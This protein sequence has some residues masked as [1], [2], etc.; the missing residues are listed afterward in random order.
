MN[1]G[2]WV[3]LWM[4]PLGLILI[5]ALV[6]GIV[7]PA[8]NV[9]SL[10]SPLGFPPTSPGIIQAVTCTPQATTPQANRDNQSNVY[11]SGIS[12]A[13]SRGLSQ[14][15]WAWAQ[16]IQHDIFAY[17][18]NA[19][20]S[21]YNISLG[22][23]GNMT[24]NALNVTSVNC[25][26]PNGRTW[27][28]DGS[29]IYSD[30]LNPARL[31]LLRTGSF[32]LMRQST[33]GYLP[34]VNGSFLAGD[35]DVNE[36]P[37]LA[38][39]VTLFVREHNFWAREL[40]QLQPLWTDDDLFWKAR[41]Y[42]LVEIQRITFEEWLPLVLGG[43]LG[44][45][46]RPPPIPAGIFPAN[47]TTVSAEFAAIG[48]EFYRS[49]LNNNNTYN[50]TNVTQSVL[51]N[52]LEGILGNAW[53]QPALSFDVRVASTQCNSTTQ[54]YDYLAAA[55]T[56]AQELGITT[57][58]TQLYLTFGG[59]AGGVNQ[60]ASIIAQTWSQAPPLYP[61]SSLQLTTIQILVEQLQRVRANDPNWYTLPEMPS[62]VGPTF[63]PL[64]SSATLASVMYRNT[65]LSPIAGASSAF[66]SS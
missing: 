66:I 30:A 56:R 10:P 45:L 62:T 3:L 57:N 43:Y 47:A 63:Y 14:L 51:N 18:V 33:G 37:Q 41:Q 24:L 26:S 46:P 28:L 6:G 39:L 61:G 49:L 13:D 42:V 54:A 64:L 52:T 55:L 53:R 16:F 19:S 1:L 44:T 31:A 59:S 29:P 35:V 58:Y 5:T 40:R 32:G 60:N 27:T 36:N 17:S 34:I 23:Y 8:P 48:S 12:P 7:A 2:Q 22:V 20:A 25:S 9:G 4:G 50:V 15:A 21:P 65:Q 38:S 11:F